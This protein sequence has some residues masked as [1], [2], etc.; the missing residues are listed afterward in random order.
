M[1]VLL[2]YYKVRPDADREALGA[3]G[4]RMHELVTRPEFGFRGS[5]Y[6]QG[7]D[8]DSLTVYEFEDLDGLERWRREPEH[9]AAQ[10][11]GPEFFEYL[12]NEVC[13]VERRDPMGSI[14]LDA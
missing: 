9:L 14:P 6:Y 3:I 1:V 7:A 11:R 2:A 10:Q 8:G 4:R 12:V 13:I 5:K